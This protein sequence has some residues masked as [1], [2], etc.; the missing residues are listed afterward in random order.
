MV[1]YARKLVRNVESYGYDSES[2]D[3]YTTL[4]S[5]GSK[6]RELDNMKIRLDH[7][8]SFLKDM[9]QVCLVVVETKI[10]YSK[11]NPEIH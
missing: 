2:V 7:V 4:D 8:E 5:R 10:S 9:A 11:N 1:K 3:S 6:T